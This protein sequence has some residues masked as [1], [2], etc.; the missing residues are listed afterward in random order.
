MKVL[1]AEDEYY[2]RQRLVKLLQ[3]CGEPLTLGAA[4]ENG[5]SALEY[6]EQNPDVDVVVT[7]VIMPGLSGLQLAEYIHRNMPCVQVI[8]VSGYE[9]FDYARKAMEYGVKQYLVKP[10]KKEQLLASLRALIDGRESHRRQVEEEVM[11]VMMQERSH[12]AR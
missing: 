2:A 11:Y 10:V 5:R 9:E 3:E 12:R 4:L 7:D 1:I 6:L 8:I